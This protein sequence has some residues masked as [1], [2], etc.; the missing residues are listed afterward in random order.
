MNGAQTVRRFLLV[1]M[2]V[3]II[4]IAGTTATGSPWQVWSWGLLHL[5]W[6]LWAWARLRA[7]KPSEG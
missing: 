4:F 6:A 5:S 3:L 7:A 2:I 1:L